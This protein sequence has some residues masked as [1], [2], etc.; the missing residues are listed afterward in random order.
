MVSMLPCLHSFCA[1]CAAQLFA[2]R[3]QT[4]CPVCRASV[5][6]R[7]VCTFV[8]AEDLAVRGPSEYGD[9]REKFGSKICAVIQQIA[10][11]LT[12]FPKDKILVFGQ[13]HDLL[14]QLSSAMPKQIQHSFLDGPLSQRCEQ[15]ENF[16]TKLSLRV[17]LLSSESQASGE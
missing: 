13:W 5:N 7:E 16:R 12:D 10:Q 3:N 6:R 8:C 11:I 9:L 4:L 2:S 14:R 1:T 15:I 17:M